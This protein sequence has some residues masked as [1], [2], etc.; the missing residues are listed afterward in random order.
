MNLNRP[1]AEAGDLEGGLGSVAPTGLEASKLTL[2]SSFANKLISGEI[3]LERPFWPCDP[4]AAY[5]FVRSHDVAT[6]LS[7]AE[8][9]LG[10][11]PRDM[12]ALLRQGYIDVHEGRVTWISIKKCARAIIGTRELAARAEIEPLKL[13]VEAAKRG[14]ERLAPRAGIWSR[15]TALAAFDLP[16]NPS[17]RFK[18]PKPGLSVRIGL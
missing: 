17:D 5:G 1:L 2:S 4:E 3:E 13:G 7:E 11:Y 9:T 18:P 10:L 15:G 12:Q 16:R 14:L 8:E 6:S